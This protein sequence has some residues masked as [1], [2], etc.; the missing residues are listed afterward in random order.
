MGSV[1]LT[2][3]AQDMFRALT[4]FLLSM[5]DLGWHELDLDTGR[6]GAERHPGFSGHT[7]PAC[8][9]L[10]DSTRACFIRSDNGEYFLSSVWPSWCRHVSKQC[11]T[12]ALLLRHENCCPREL[13]CT[14]RP[15]KR[16]IMA[17]ACR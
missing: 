10:P 9:L 16:L 1:V 12:S 11:V 15:D 3:E 8:L 17:A 13:S 5:T 7:P 2:A 6:L 4:C 14:L